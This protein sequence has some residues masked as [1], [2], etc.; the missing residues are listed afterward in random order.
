[1]YN[2]WDVHGFGL[3]QAIWEIHLGSYDLMLLTETKIMYAVYYK[4]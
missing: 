3:P 1:M 4:N 2:I